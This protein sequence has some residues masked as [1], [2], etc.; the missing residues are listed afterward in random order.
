[1][2]FLL[3]LDSL[4]MYQSVQDVPLHF[5]E[6]VIHDGPLSKRLVELHAALVR[7]PGDMAHGA[8]LLALVHDLLGQHA[9]PP[10]PASI[11]ARV[12]QAVMAVKAYV[13]ANYASPIRLDALAEISGLGVFQLIRGF[14]AATGLTPYA[15]VEQLRI[16]RALEMLRAGVRASLVAH[17]TGFSD[18]SHLTRHIKRVLGV[19][20]ATYQRWT[21]ARMRS[22]A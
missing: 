1:V 3:S 12:R 21:L 17:E 16:R 14:R 20:P 11:D 6:P 15:Y 22:R 13:D 4:G 7:D 9:G 8:P 19:P 2:A 10:D 5:D 18:Q